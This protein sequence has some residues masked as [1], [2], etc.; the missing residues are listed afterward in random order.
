MYIQLAE[1]PTPIAAEFNTGY[2]EI[3]LW[4]REWHEFTNFPRQTRTI[5]GRPSFDFLCQ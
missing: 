5:M 3:L 2:G 4:E 1:I